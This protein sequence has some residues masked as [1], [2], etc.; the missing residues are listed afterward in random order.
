MKLLLGL[1]L[2][3]HGLI[4]ISYFTPKPDD[5]NYPFDFT[6]G[7]FAA[8]AGSRAK[9]VGSLLAIVA[10][11]CFILCG[12][13]IIGI[14]GLENVWKVFITISTIS[15]LALLSLFW[16]TWLVLGVV[17][18]AVLLFVVYILHWNLIG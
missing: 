2:I 9:Y 8:L 14:P 12:L 10:I 3:A 18:N 15:S 13:G 6:K 16:Q 11:A 17:I 5:P 4:H 7:W 1:F